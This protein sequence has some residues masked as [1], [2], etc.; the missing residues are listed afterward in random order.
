MIDHYI[1]DLEN[2]EMAL[3]ANDI[4]IYCKRNMLALMIL[5]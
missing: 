4:E 1:K 3:V 2:I 5:S